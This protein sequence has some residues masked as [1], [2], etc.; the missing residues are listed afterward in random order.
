M[1]IKM[2]NMAHKAASFFPPSAQSFF[3][4]QLFSGHTW[5][6]SVRT[7]MIQPSS[8]QIDSDN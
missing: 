6:L 4:N 8:L 7:L 2:L 5:L 3:R 1:H